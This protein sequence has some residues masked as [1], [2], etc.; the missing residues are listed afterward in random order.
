ML[1]LCQ[2]RGETVC[3]CWLGSCGCL[4]CHGLTVPLQQSLGVGVGP[5]PPLPLAPILGAQKKKGG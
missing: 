4:K 5:V 1:V 3:I 2:A